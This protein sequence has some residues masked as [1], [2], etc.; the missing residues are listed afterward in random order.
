MVLD[1]VLRL[2]LCIIIEQVAY[3]NGRLAFKLHKA[4]ATT[5][6]LGVMGRCNQNIC[7]FLANNAKP[8]E[9]AGKN[10]VRN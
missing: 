8:K 5:Y 6:N 7:V 9:R 1:F 3:L 4:D 2:K 10:T